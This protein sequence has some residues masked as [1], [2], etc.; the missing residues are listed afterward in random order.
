MSSTKKQKKQISYKS[1][2][3]KR[4]TNLSNKPKIPNK[5]IAFSVEKAENIDNNGKKINGD[6]FKKYQNGVLK[7]QIFVSKARENKIIKKQI[8]RIKQQKKHGGATAAAGKDIP[9]EKKQVIIVQDGTEVA[10]T[11]FIAGI[12]SGAGFAIGTSVIDAIFN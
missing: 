8:K 2:T 11:S 12:G 5:G 3:I 9:V 1:K 6:I 10:K 4:F 7:R